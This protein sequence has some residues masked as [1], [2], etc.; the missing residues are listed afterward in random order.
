MVAF[1]VVYDGVNNQVLCN[2]D[3]PD[4]VFAPP[5]D[6]LSGWEVSDI[7]DGARFENQ[8]VAVNVARSLTETFQANGNETN[9]KVLQ[10]SIEVVERC[11]G[12]IM[13]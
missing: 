13:S 6:K 10:I 7:Q 12:I 8:D 2:W 9:F 1:F 4:W 3:S 11:T 5:L